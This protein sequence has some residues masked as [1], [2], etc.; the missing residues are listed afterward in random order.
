RCPGRRGRTAGARRDRAGARRAAADSGGAAAEAADRV[1]EAATHSRR[2]AGDAPRRAR[3]RGSAARYGGR[4]ARPRGRRGR[5]GGG[6]R[7]PAARAA[8]PPV[9][10]ERTLPVYPQIARARG[11]EGQVVLS[12]VVGRDGAIE[13]DVTVV[14]S[15]P[16]LD[17]AAVTALRHWRFTPGRDA[18]G[19]A[20]RVLLEVPI[21]FHL[22]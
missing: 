8:R 20:V 9:V 19:R 21:R 4:H 6:G 15:M 11:I 5:G 1:A 7:T 18:D 12:A 17:E 16:G 10:T 13:N 3:D 14:R 2:P 22:H